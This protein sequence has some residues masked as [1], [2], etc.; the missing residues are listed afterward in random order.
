[1]EEDVDVNVDN[2]GGSGS[3][4]EVAVAGADVEVVSAVMLVLLSA[5]LFSDTGCVFSR[6]ET[7][8]D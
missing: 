4:E 3:E 8:E 2:C 7:E 5:A 1:M 6:E